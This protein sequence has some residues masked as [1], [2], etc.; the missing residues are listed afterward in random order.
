[1]GLY[2]NVI[3]GLVL[4]TNKRE[5]RK[6]QWPLKDQIYLLFYWIYIE[7]WILFLYIIFNADESS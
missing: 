5:S 2:F 7:I 4:F 6:S 3:I 1:M